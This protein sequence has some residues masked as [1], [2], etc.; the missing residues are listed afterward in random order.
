MPKGLF[1]INIGPNKDTKDRLK[2]YLICIRAFYK[3]A[4]YLTINISSPNTVNLR[5]FHNKDELNEL[6]KAIELEKK[7]LNST[8]PI[9]VK[10]SPDIDDD[11]IDEI[12]ETLLKYKVVFAIITNSTD[13]NRDN[14]K[15]IKKF[16]KGGLSGKPL[17]ARSNIL[18]N[19][20]YKNFKNEIKIIGVGGV[21]SG[22]SAYEKF[23]NGACLIQLYT[24]MIYQGPNI[25]S[26]INKELSEILK[27]KGI[28]NFK[29]VIGTKI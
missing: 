1:G 27:N 20:F 21:D 13:K 7:N 4:D 28:K 17:E 23:L 25:V 26:K 3:L 2:D 18:I 29:E 22:K 24:G 11:N 16:E 12:S 5:S 9:A 14:L 15:N 6:L 8:I 10:I 19:K